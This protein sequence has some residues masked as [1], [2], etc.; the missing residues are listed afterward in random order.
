MSDNTVDDNAIEIRRQ[1]RAAMED[2]ICGSRGPKMRR[3]MYQTMHSGSLEATKSFDDNCDLTDRRSLESIVPINQATR[4]KMVNN[5]LTDLKRPE[6]DS[7]K[8]LNDHR[9]LP[10]SLFD[11][12]QNN[13]KLFRYASGPEIVV[14]GVNDD[15]TSLGG[16][17]GETGRSTFGK[18][19]PRGRMGASYP[20]FPFRRCDTAP[21]GSCDYD[22]EHG[23]V[24]P[25]G[26]KVWSAVTSTVAGS[27]SV[28]STTSFIRVQI[29]A[30]FQ[31]G[32]AI[33]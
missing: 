6:T 16:N 23:K 11:C 29:S 10:K 12:R 9:N 20:R 33:K 19:R 18:A 5:E 1:P 25:G 22:D 28:H 4:F 26:R 30:M 3:L 21:S 15:D 2:P 24:G 17:G 7:S 13:S 31:V 27:P 32:T 14:H 8:T